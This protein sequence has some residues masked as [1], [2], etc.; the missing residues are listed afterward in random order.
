MKTTI[1]LLCLVFLFTAG[2][3]AEERTIILAYGDFP[4][5]EFRSEG[6]AKGVLVDMVKDIFNE[7]GIPLE[8]QFIPFKRAFE[9]TKRG[10]IDGIFSFFKTPERLAYFDYSSPLIKN[11]LV[12]FVRKD[13]KMQ[14]TGI[15]SLKGKRIAVML[16]FSYGPEF[17]AATGV[18]RD[19]S[20]SHQGSL[21]KVN[22]GR[23][24]AYIC[25]KVVGLYTAQKYNLLDELKYIQKPVATMNGHIGFTKEKLADVISRV[26]AVISRMR[27]AGEINKRINEYIE[28]LYNVPRS[29]KQEFPS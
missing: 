3:H 12:L 22:R 24:D 25:D 5:Y 18:L 14:Y 9:D 21:Q 13:S 15:N 11:E 10:E 8:L 26:N 20:T 29:E 2:S 19:I 23:V 28:S 27:Q 6:G 17:D 7:A 16:G 1:I 4:P